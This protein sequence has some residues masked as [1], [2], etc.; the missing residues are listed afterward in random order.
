MKVKVAP[1]CRTEKLANHFRGSHL[2]VFVNALD[3]THK[4]I[5]K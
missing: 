2:I 1:D 3:N 4:A 5:K